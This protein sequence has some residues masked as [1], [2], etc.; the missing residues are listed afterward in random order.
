MVERDVLINVRVS[1]DEREK[2]HAIARAADETAAQ[3]IRRF[4]RQRYAAEFGKTPPKTKGG[5]R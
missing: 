3:T 5:K 4:I 1:E 2:L